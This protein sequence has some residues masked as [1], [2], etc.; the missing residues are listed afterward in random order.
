[1]DLEWIQQEILHDFQDADMPPLQYVGELLKRQLD[2]QYR[3]FHYDNYNY[4]VE[5]ALQ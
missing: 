3:E 2:N 1:M 5:P 4:L